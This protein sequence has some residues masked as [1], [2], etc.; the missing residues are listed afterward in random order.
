MQAAD[1][2]SVAINSSAHVRTPAGLKAVAARLFWMRRWLAVLLLALLPFQLTWAAVAPYCQH[3][4][5]QAG[6]FGHHEHQHHAT[7][8]GDVDGTSD[9]D[10]SPL[11]VDLDCGQCHGAFVGLNHVARPHVPP[12]PSARPSV[13]VID[14]AAA[15][16]DERPERPNWSDLA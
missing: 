1:R 7:P 10:K 16:T 2:T 12:I 15:G 14:G 3:E 11:T 5:T 6:H 9:A 8:Q 4:A 13:P